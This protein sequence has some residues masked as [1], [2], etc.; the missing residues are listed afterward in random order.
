MSLFRLAW[1]SMLSRKSMVG[2]LMLS[3]GLSSMV[4]MGVQKI[5][6]S[7]QTSLSYSVSG[8]DLIVGARSGD[9]QLLLYTIFRVGKPVANMSWAALE[10]IRALPAVKWVIPISLGD[11]HKG[12]PVIGT[13]NAY[14]DHYQYG[15]KQ[16]LAFEYGRA[17]QGPLDVVVGAD[18][19]R[20]LGYRMGDSLY[21]SHGT[22]RIARPHANTVFNIVGILMPTGTP[23][24]ASLH[25][26]VTAMDALH[27]RGG[28]ATDTPPRTITG[29]LVGLHSTLS[30]FSVQRHIIDAFDEPLSAVIPGVAFSQLWAS[31]SMINH[32]F[33]I[34]TIL[35][36]VISFMSLLLALCMS[37]HHRQKELA[38]LRAMGCRPY[39]I[40]LLMML[41]AL[42]ITC[43]SV[44]L[45]MGLMM[46]VG[47]LLA[48][49]LQAKMGLVLAMDTLT[50]MD[51]VWMGVM[52]VFGTL[53]STIPAIQ[54][55]RK[56]I[57]ES[58]LH[59]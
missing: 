35:V 45:G 41:E 24:D 11:S 16:S 44:G 29:G 25:V 40:F 50:I 17:L 47:R 38:L 14:F 36:S 55:Y 51:G 15:Q 31:L 19:A 58:L 26:H 4:V 53:I 37:I 5:K 49:F 57:S 20:T 8:T 56:S 10:Q 33:L 43:L 9:I 39:Q 32:A 54:A 23:V 7:A 22:G 48:P 30:I 27:S 52:V 34:I 6:Y 42:L 21:L 1:K 12:Y 13:T 18:V 59:S 3:I 46:M 2:L 28:P